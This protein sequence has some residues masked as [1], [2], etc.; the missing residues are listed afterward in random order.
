M[1]IIGSTVKTGSTAM[2]VT[3][4]SD[5]SFSLTGLNVANGINVAVATDPDYSTRRNASFKSRMPSISN[6]T[7]TKGKF[8]VVYVQPIVLSSGTVVFNTLRLGLE[9]HPEL[10]A[11]SMKDLRYVGAQIL[12]GSSYDDFWQAGALT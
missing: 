11:A 4:G 3:G 7:Y 2:S 8:E 1:A 9:T 10:A 6:G 5:I 12:T